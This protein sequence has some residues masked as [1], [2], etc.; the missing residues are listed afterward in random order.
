MYMSAITQLRGT[1]KF[2]SG[3]TGKSN[4]EVLNHASNLL[5]KALIKLE[6]E[7]L[8][9]LANYRLV[10]TV[11]CIS[12]YMLLHLM[13][14]LV[15]VSASLWN[16]SFYLNVFLMHYGHQRPLRTR[17]NLIARQNNKRNWKML[18]THLQL[19][20]LQGF[21]LCFMIWLNKWPILAINNSYLGSTG[22]IF[23]HSLC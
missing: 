22:F 17:V 13:M 16:L 20:F 21:Y 2:F 11:S 15:L 10:F 8:S 14:C 9:L 1:V 7:F 5:S 12:I 18:F 23:S 6:E 19:L 3:T 4:E